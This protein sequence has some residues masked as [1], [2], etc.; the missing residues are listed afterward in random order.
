MKYNI[1]K[2]EKIQAKAMRLAWETWKGLQKEIA[3]LN[4]DYEEGEEWDESDIEDMEFL[5]KYTWSDVLKEAWAKA[6]AHR[7]ETIINKTF[8]EDEVTASVWIKH[9]Y[10]RV[11]LNRG[12]K[13]LGFVDITTG[14]PD[15]S[16]AKFQI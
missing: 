14:T 12:T 10:I 9:G 6:K 15:W 13:K 1:E 4:A 16:Q 8:S 2:Q 7:I 11:Y 5:K 3:S